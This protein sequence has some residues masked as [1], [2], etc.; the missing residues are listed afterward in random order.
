MIDYGMT[1]LLMVIGATGCWAGM[2]LC[3]YLAASKN[4]KLR[5]IGLYFCVYAAISLVLIGW[6]IW[7][8]ATPDP[9]GIPSWLA[10]SLRTAS[11]IAAAWAAWRVTRI[12]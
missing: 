5:A 12:G 4:P 1:G 8:I 6:S 2:T 7:T 9:A 10:I 3:R 11:V